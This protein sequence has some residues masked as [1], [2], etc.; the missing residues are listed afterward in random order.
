MTVIAY[1]GQSMSVDSLLTD[2]DLR[3]GMVRKF[4]HLP[5]GSVVFC[6]G[7]WDAAQT[8]FDALERGEVPDASLFSDAT[9]VTLD[10][11]GQVWE[12]NNYPRKSRIAKPWAWGSGGDLAIG[13][14][15]AG[16]SSRQAAQIAAKLDTACGGKIWTFGEPQ[17]PRET[18]PE[19]TA[20][21]GR[22]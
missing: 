1:D 8:I 5:D 22:I 16:A 10:A 17:R 20:W 15:Y 18:E 6:T 2:G 7:N 21:L 14:L 12:Q 19:E 11:R 13:A 4:R 3:A 9:I